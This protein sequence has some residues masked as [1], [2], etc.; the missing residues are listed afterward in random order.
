[1]FIGC[2]PVKSTAAV[3]VRD[4]ILRALNSVGLNPGHMVAVAF[5]GA[6]NMSGKK[7]GVQALLKEH[8]ANLIYVQCRSH[9]LQ[10]AL[11]RAAERCAP[12][13]RV[14]AIINKLYA[15]FKHSPK[16]LAVLESVQCAVD[17]T[18]HKLIQAGSTRWLSY[19]GS[20]AVVHKHYT[21]ICLSLE[22]I[23]ADATDLSCDAGGLLL[24]LRNVQTLHLICILQ[25]IFQPLAR[26]SRALQTKDANISTSVALIKA[27]IK[28][29]KDF[30]SEAVETDVAATLS[31]LKDAGVRMTDSDS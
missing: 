7:G 24:E 22:S 6:A 12:V 10:L 16:R 26:L 25:N 18:S 30:S 31:K 5:D 27:T 17:G 4:C 1:M 19:D 3:D 8:S 13:K 29:I 21:A 15:M 14:L 28:G 11:V 23:Y 20:I 9:L 2:W